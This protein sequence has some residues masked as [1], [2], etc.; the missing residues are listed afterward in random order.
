MHGCNVD[1]VKNTTCI[2][3]QCAITANFSQQYSALLHVLYKVGLTRRPCQRRKAWRNDQRCYQLS[4][5]TGPW[6]LTQVLSTSTVTHIFLRK[7]IQH[8]FLNCLWQK[9]FINGKVQLLNYIFNFSSSI[10]PILTLTGNFCWCVLQS[11][12]SFLQHP[13]PLYTFEWWLHHY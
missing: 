9:E 10:M 6:Q 5:L 8:T 11:G 4:C 2:L 3:F 13:F 7:Q 12:M 1:G